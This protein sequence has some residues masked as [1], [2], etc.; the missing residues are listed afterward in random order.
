MQPWDEKD[1]EQKSH[2]YPGE[3]S[4]PIMVIH[5]EKDIQPHECSKI[6]TAH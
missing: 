2:N 1:H 3:K 4:Q 6:L 5:P